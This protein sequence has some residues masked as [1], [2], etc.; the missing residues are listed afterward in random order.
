M[1]SLNLAR[2]TELTELKTNKVGQLDFKDDKNEVILQMSWSAA[3]NGFYNVKSS[4]FPLI[5]QVAESDMTI[6]LTDKNNVNNK[7]H[8]LDSAKVNSTESLKANL[9]NSSV[10]ISK[11]PVNN[12]LQDAGKVKK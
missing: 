10:D 4:K 1:K 12:K 9:K 8:A 11:I 5:I 7:D 6:F 3:Q 2:F